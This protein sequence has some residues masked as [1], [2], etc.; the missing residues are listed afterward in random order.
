MAAVL[1]EDIRKRSDREVGEGR[2]YH[3]TYYGPINVA[4][5]AA[6]LPV[7]GATMPTG[8]DCVAGTL[9]TGVSDPRPAP[10][11]AVSMVTVT[12]FYPGVGAVA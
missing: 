5:L 4:A 11:R 1:T 7:I 8:S 9:V 10:N 3:R 6:L 2:E 12:G